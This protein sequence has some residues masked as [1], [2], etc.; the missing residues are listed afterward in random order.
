MAKASK[1]ALE[2]LKVSQLATLVGRKPLKRGRPAF[3]LKAKLVDK[4][5]ELGVTTQEIESV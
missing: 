1:K 2:E 5:L 4:A 3:A